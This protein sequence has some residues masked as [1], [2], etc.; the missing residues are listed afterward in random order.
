LTTSTRKQFSPARSEEGSTVR[1]VGA[2]NP[3]TVPTATVP[4]G[5]FKET[6][7]ELSA[8]TWIGNF[9]GTVNP[10]HKVKQN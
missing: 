9:G 1:V 6:C 8:K 2:V 7:A 5:V 4:I 10:E 3:G